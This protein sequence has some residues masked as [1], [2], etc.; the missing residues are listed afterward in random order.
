MAISHYYV[1]PAGGSDVTGDGL[2]DGTAWASVQHALDNITQ[3]TDG[4]QINIVAGGTD[5]LSSSLSLTT[6]GTPGETQRLILA[7][8]TATA[9]DGGYGT[10]DC[11]GNTLI[12]G[13][14]DYVT[15]KNLRVKGG[16]VTVNAIVL[17]D[18]CHVQECEVSDC[19][20][21]IQVGQWGVVQ[22]CYVV[23]G[24]SYGI[25]VERGSI[26][27]RNFVQNGSSNDWVYAI[28]LSA[29][30]GLCGQ[31]IGNI[32][33]IDSST[34]GIRAFGQSAYIAGNS[35]LASFGSG[36]GIDLSVDTDATVINNVIEGFISG[37]GIYGTA[38]YTQAW[39]A[40]NS[41]YNCLTTISSALVAWLGIENNEELTS[42][43]F[44]KIGGANFLNRFNYFRPVRTGNVIGGAYPTGGE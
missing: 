1:D 25:G 7:G 21:A 29:N 5:T 42:S 9:N 36:Y 37:T 13:G 12:S 24:D 30:S 39:I 11:N 33:S 32:I 3:G 15:L 40:Y 41:I 10:I 31:A 23:D 17:D 6:Y 35:I 19:N 20:N 38:S 8:C 18:W 2:S 22:N 43:P 26:A 27:F 16:G 44:A 4:D 28:Q 14:P 34:G